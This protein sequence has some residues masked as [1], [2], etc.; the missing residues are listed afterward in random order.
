MK[1]KPW[2]RFLRSPRASTKLT[3]RVL[4]Q[5]LNVKLSH[6]AYLEKDRRRPYLALLSGIADLLGLEKEPLFLLG[7]PEARSLLSSR[8]QMPSEDGCSKPV[9]R[10]FTGD[11]SLL[12]RH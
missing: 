2:V 9:W 5:R 6:V 7:H 10:D 1:K 3:Q 12:A 4:A 8:R 11:K